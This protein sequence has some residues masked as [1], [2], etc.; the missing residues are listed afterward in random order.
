MSTIDMCICIKHHTPYAIILPIVGLSM[1]C[2][3]YFLDTFSL[4]KYISL[5]VSSFL[6]FPFLL[7]FESGYEDIATIVL[8]NVVARLW[9]MPVMFSGDMAISLNLIW[10]FPLS[11]NHD[12]YLSLMILIIYYCRHR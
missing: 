3:P 2:D 12:N 7:F 9:E 10:K 6:L 4:S 1:A 5:W 8:S 11:V